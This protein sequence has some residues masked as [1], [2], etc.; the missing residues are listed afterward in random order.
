MCKQLNGGELPAPRWGKSNEEC[1]IVFRALGEEKLRSQ[2]YLFY[3]SH[4]GGL[5]LL[6][7]H[8]SSASF[9]LIS[10]TR[11]ASHL[12]I[13]PPPVSPLPPICWS[14][15]RWPPQP[16][17]GQIINSL[18]VFGCFSLDSKHGNDQCSYP[19]VLSFGVRRYIV[20]T[21]HVTIMYRC[22][23]KDKESTTITKH[24]WSWQTCVCWKYFRVNAHICIYIYLY[25]NNMNT[26]QNNSKYQYWQNT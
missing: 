23:L 18:I 7:S 26:C 9:L 17:G 10:L 5:R 22:F 11:L 16:F 14:C 8:L 12:H 6:S 2:W 24:H 25:L 13:C 19:P 1:C 20:T 4:L 3:L 21:D 15:L